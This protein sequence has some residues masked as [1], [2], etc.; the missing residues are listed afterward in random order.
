MTSS[1]L[2]QKTLAIWD[3]LG[4]LFSRTLLIS[5]ELARLTNGAGV[6][7]T[8]FR[9]VVSLER[10]FQNPRWLQNVFFCQNPCTPVDAHC[11]PTLRV[12][13]DVNSIDWISVHMREDLFMN[14]KSVSRFLG[15]CVE[16]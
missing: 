16:V 4:T 6:E 11:P 13:E 3:D 1:F 10:L 14:L 5:G 12:F 8:L 7:H 9:K 15:Y 2:S